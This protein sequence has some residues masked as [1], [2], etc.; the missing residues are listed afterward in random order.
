MH[1]LTEAQ[2]PLAPLAYDHEPECV[3]DVLPAPPQLHLVPNQTADATRRNYRGHLLIL[4]NDVE[5]REL[6]AVFL[7][8]RGF[9]VWEAATASEAQAMLAHRIQI[10]Y[11]SIFPCR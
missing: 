5:A 7:R 2:V 11:Y 1:G 3:N 6:L 4:D 9:R 8:R 10:S